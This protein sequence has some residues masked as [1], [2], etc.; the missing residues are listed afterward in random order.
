LG[1]VDDSTP[2]SVVS[3]V[4]SANEVSCRCD[5]VA[6]WLVVVG[7]AD[8]I[9]FRISVVVNAAVVG[10][11]VVVVTVVVTGFAVVVGLSVVV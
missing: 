6:D 9:G 11:T 1:D 3:V 4:V 10:F 5:V 7:C 2:T 8:V